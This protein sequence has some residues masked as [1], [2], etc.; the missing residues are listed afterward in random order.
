M[1][2]NKPGPITPTS[3]IGIVAPASATLDQADNLK[4]VRE[5]ELR[6]MKVVLDIHSNEKDGYLSAPDNLRARALNSMI[7]DPD[8]DAIFCLRGGYGCVRILE[9][10]DYDTAQ[11]NPKLIVGYSDIT[12]LHC[13]L[14]QRAGWTA[15]HGPMVAVDWPEIGNETEEIFWSVASGNILAPLPSPGGHQLVSFRSGQ[16][17]GPLIGG[18]LSTLVRLLGTPYFPDL[19]GAILFLEDVGEAPYRLD[20]M[21]A[22]LRLAGVLDKLSGLVLG[23]FTECEPPPDR[24]SLTF[25]RI[26]DDYFGDAQYPVATDLL[27]GHIPVKSAIPFGIRAKLETNENRATLSMLESVVT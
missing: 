19:N 10:I 9:L 2:P 25:N 3:T 27:Y 24:P 13:A 15:L 14:Y 22:Q 7:A 8:I 20:A 23:A 11:S 17:E 18:N 12:A 21:F 16:A 1:T 26:L 5:L 6:G 4:G